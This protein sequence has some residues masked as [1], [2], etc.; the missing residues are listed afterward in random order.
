MAF[1]ADHNVPDPNDLTIADA[2]HNVQH[3]CLTLD[4]IAALASNLKKL[5]QPYLLPSLYRILVK[6]ASRNVHIRAAAHRTL[7][8]IAAAFDRPDNVAGLL[9]D[10]FD[11]ILF[12]VQMA[13]R[14]RSQTECVAAL[15]MLAV[16]LRYSDMET[17]AGQWQSI[18]QTVLEASGGQAM[19][20]TQSAADEDEKALSFLHLFR[21]LLEHMNGKGERAI[22]QDHV[23]GS[24]RI[25]RDEQTV[26]DEW[27]RLLDAEQDADGDDDVDN[28]DIDDD[29]SARAAAAAADAAADDPSDKP[30]VSISVQIT[31][32]LMKRCIYYLPHRSRAVQCMALDTLCCGFRVLQRAAAND[33]LLPLVHTMWRPF[34]ER[35]RGGDAVV[36]RR[37]FAVML[38][39]SGAAKDFM[40]KRT[41]T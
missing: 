9:A 19:W 16:L 26:R 27:L 38:V 1:N 18:V 28:M 34:V 21:N 25:Q 3:I 10:N 14:K 4:A 29:A 8:C 5:Y 23:D 20:R 22:D 7:C 31:E 24:P 2:A 36:V 40:Y 37:C 33:V 13:L 15:E 41:A 32:A 11:Y 12:A 35:V 6:A 39:M 30:V 17:L